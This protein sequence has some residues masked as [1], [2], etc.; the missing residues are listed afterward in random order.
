MSKVIFTNGDTYFINFYIDFDFKSNK[1]F[2]KSEERFIKV[3]REIYKHKNAPYRIIRF[4]VTVS[5]NQ[6]LKQT[7]KKDAD[8]KNIVKNAAFS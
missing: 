5:K 2:K 1:T 8:K 4:K 3:R 7:W 6:H